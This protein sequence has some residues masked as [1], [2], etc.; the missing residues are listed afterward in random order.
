MD[1]T[2]ISTRIFSKLCGKLHSWRKEEDLQKWMIFYNNGAP[3][4]N[5]EFKPVK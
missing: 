5:L 3:L 4:L 1:Y 2:A